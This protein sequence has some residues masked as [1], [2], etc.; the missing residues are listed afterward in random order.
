MNFPLFHHLLR[1][2]VVT[3]T[4]PCISSRSHRKNSSWRPYGFIWPFYNIGRKIFERILYENVKIQADQQE[5]VSNTTYPDRLFSKRSLWYIHWHFWWFACLNVQ[6]FKLLIQNV[7]SY[8]QFILLLVDGILDD[9]RLLNSL[10]IDKNS[11]FEYSNINL[12]EIHFLKFLPSYGYKF[13]IFLKT[14]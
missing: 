11:L 3:K 12:S 8:M 7:S 9:K 10:K 1:F 2:L 14:F 13:G 4:S 5:K 6:S